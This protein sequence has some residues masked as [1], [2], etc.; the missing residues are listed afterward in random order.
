[1]ERNTK[2]SRK[3][4]RR[5]VLGALAL[6]ALGGPQVAA[7]CAASFDAPSKVQ[8]LRILAVTPDHPYVTFDPKEPDKDA[9]VTFTMT[10]HDGLVNA[11]AGDAVRPIQIVWLGGC[12]DPPGDQYFACYEQLAQVLEDVFTGKTP[13]DGIAA[14]GLFLDKFTL[15]I[16]RDIVTRRPAPPV[17]PHY[18][19]AY[20]FFL[21]CAGEVKAVPPDGTGRAPDF[22]LGC[23]DPDTGVRLGPDSFV[24]GY[25]QV[26]S[27]ADERPNTIPMINGMKLNDQDLPEGN[28]LSLVPAVKACPLTEDERRSQGGCD[29]EV[30]AGCDAV[31]IKAIVDP[32]KVADDDPE[33]FGQDGK[34]LTEAVW[35]SYF[36]DQGDIGPGL[37]L[38]NDAV[39]GFN[40]DLGTQWLPPAEPGVATIWAVLRDARG[41]SSVAKRFIRVEP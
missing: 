28:D 23:F 21:A 6:A 33:G 29:E 12:F 25:T 15:T 35:I 34:K 11:N 9:K 40:P 3:K 37:K 38:V 16:P 7:G 30:P 22:P 5:A 26:Y 32:E 19:I 39:S 36:A 2:S 4:L 41:G 1:M 18:G 10:L 14:F 27:F 13:P 8:T 20:V 17:G 24:P 31:D